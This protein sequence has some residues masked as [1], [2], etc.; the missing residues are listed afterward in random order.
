MC[1]HCTSRVIFI[2]INDKWSKCMT[3]VL[4]NKIYISA[5]CVVV[6]SLGLLLSGWYS[7]VSLSGEDVYWITAEVWRIVNI[8]LVILILSST[9]SL[10]RSIYS[11]LSMIVWIRSTTQDTNTFDRI[12]IYSVH[13]GRHE[14]ST[15]ETGHCNACS[16]TTKRWQLQ[17]FIPPNLRVKTIIKWTCYEVAIRWTR[18]HFI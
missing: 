10:C 6:I 3:N 5:E 8:T 7:A 18:S 13:F 11:K 16:L 9:D 1:E 14:G 12:W 17:I 15:W 2:R 4:W